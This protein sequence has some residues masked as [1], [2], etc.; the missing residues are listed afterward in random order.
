MITWFQHIPSDLHNNDFLVFKITHDIF[1]QANLTTTYPDAA[2]FTF[3]SHLFVKDW[4]SSGNPNGPIN[5]KYLKRTPAIYTRQKNI[6]L[7]ARVLDSSV[8]THEFQPQPGY[9]R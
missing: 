7:P 6:L 3:K 9:E 8:S 5:E 4:G 1:F 2:G